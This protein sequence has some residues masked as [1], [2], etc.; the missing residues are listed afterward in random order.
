MFK[1]LIFFYAFLLIWGFITPPIYAKPTLH[2]NATKDKYQ[3][4]HDALYR[5]IINRQKLTRQKSGWYFLGGFGVLDTIKDYQNKEVRNYLATLNLKTGVQS[6]FKKY[7]GVRGFFA[8]DLGGGRV[9]YQ[10]HKDPTGSF[11]TMLSVGMDILMEFPLGS[12]KHYL[13]AFGGAGVAMV[14][15]MDR[16]DFKF[17]KHAMYSGGLMI[18]GGLTLTLFLK[19]RLEWGFKILPTARMFSNSK[20]FETLPLF[21]MAYSY[22]F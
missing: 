9:N 6:F 22:K 1:K 21:Y 5:D 18:D 12:Y 11:F 2:D 14:V 8:W 17:F 10:S 13:G 3:A 16:Q 19:H 15:Y 20:R 4:E 7:V